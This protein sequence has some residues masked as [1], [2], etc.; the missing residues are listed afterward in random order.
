MDWGR[1]R[2]GGRAGWM[3]DDDTSC[4]YVWREGGEGFSSLK[5]KDKD[6][7]DRDRCT[8]MPSEEKAASRWLL[9]VLLLLL[10][11]LLP[12]TGGGRLR[13]EEEEDDGG[14]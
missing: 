6:K 1:E 10:L 3:N 5:Y 11:L 7:V 13:E 2:E 9:L 12:L 4:P 14:T 8:F